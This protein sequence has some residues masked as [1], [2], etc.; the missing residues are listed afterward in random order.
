MSKITEGVL[1]P[2][3]G[4]CARHVMS[5]RVHCAYDKPQGILISFPEADP[6]NLR[7]L[8]ASTVTLQLDH[9]AEAGAQFLFTGRLAPAR[10]SAYRLTIL[11]AY[12]EMPSGERHPL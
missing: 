7:Y 6:G 12:Y 2:Q 5:Q 9:P 10:N 8:L 11:R 1:A 4:G 3:S